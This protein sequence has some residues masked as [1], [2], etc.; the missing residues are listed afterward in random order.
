LPF[1]LD[2]GAM[3]A[4]E[5]PLT[6]FVTAFHDVQFMD[7]GA[8]HRVS[9][10]PLPGA[11]RWRLSIREGALPARDTVLVDT[12]LVGSALPVV[13]QV[14]ALDADDASGAPGDLLEP[15]LLLPGTPAN[16]RLQPQSGERILVRWNPGTG[17]VHTWELERQGEEGGFVPLVALGVDTLL[18]AD[19]T[20]VDG[21]RW[22]YRARA[23]N[24]HGVSAWTNTVAA[25]APLNVPENLAIALDDLEISLSWTERSRSEEGIQV[26]RALGNGSFVPVATL[27][28]NA[29]GWIDAPLAERTRHRYRV[30]AFR[31][32][33]VSA[34]TPVVEATTPLHVPSSPAG[35]SAAA[36]SPIQIDLAWGAAR[37]I[38]ENYEVERRRP[39]DAFALLATL[40]GDAQVYA[41]LG[42]PAGTTYEYRVR[43]V[44]ESGPGLYSNVAT[45]TTHAAPR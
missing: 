36:I 22:E 44:N 30:R 10:H 13:Y 29:A 23:R 2:V 32:L 6:G 17:F 26:E 35:L 40:A 14:Q 39:G 12:A 15:G 4:V 1:D 3:V 37:G 18:F 42:L 33:L 38:V 9:W 28:V 16:L 20:V 21:R 31:G 5:V 11:A 27:P 8:S 7:E 19:S 43:A 24:T 41:D 34:Y 45:A 25:V